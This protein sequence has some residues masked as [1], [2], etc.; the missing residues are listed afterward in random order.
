MQICEYLP[1]LAQQGRHVAV[2]RSLTTPEPDHMPGYAYLHT[3][4]RG[5][6]TVE[7][8]SW[9][10]VVAREW[11]TEDGDLPA[12]MVLN[13]NPNGQSPH[14][15]FLGAQYAPQAILKPDVLPDDIALPQGLDENRLERRLQAVKDLNARFAQRAD[16]VSISAYDWF[17]AKAAR[18]RKSPALKAFDLNSE[19][20]KTRAAYGIRPLKEGE[21]APEIDW[22]RS[23]LLARRLV[24]HGV[25]FVEINLNVW[26]THVDNFNVNK[27]NMALL[28]PAFSALLAD[29]S[30]R[31]RLD[32]T[33]VI[34]MG[35]MGRTPKIND[36]RGRD[37]W[38]IFSAVLAGG[39]IRGGQVIGASDAK[40]EQVKD[41]PMSVPDLYATFLAA[42]GI[43]NNKKYPAPGGRPVA[44]ADKGK[45]VQVIL[46]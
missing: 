15:G 3:G 26:D 6:D 13:F 23:V 24:E 8:P 9:G 35:E 38:G 19:T 43:D 42:F 18:F 20:E 14:P 45:V 17:T 21:A 22:G 16:S 40:G 39:G 10:S 5:D 37:H 25:R 29:L 11:S 34:C 27:T 36:Q 46:R 12:Y 41:R 28:D 7:Y 30:D 4:N 31:G 44:L 2:V 33:L 32:E 1:K